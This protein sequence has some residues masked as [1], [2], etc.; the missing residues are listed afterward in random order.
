MSQQVSTPE[1]KDAFQHS[2]IE[3]RPGLGIS[4][5]FGSEKTGMPEKPMIVSDEDE[6]E[7][8]LAK[9]LAWA[10]KRKSEMFTA[11]PTAKVSQ[12]ASAERVPQLKSP[13]DKVFRA[14]KQ[15][16]SRLSVLAAKAKETIEQQFDSSDE[17][18]EEE[19]AFDGKENSFYLKEKEVRAVD[20]FVISD[21]DG[22]EE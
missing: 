2:L 6:D 15:L 12:T 13:V 21:E 8:P 20:T 14:R 9:G 19:A 3:K 17:E 4:T 11:S 18:D 7:L 22:D 10:I 16:F 5:P 1:H